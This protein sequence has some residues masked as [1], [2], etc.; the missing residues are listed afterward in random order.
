MAH[1][2]KL[3]YRPLSLSKLPLEQEVKKVTWSIQNN[4]LTLNNPTAFY[5]NL[6]KVEVDGREIKTTSYIAPHA[7]EKVAIGFAASA[8]SLVGIT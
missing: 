1:R 7:Q 8:Q 6:A 4:Q 2:I 3:I 5:I